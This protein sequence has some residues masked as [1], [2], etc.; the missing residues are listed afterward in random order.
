MASETARELVEEWLDED[1]YITCD[2]CPME[3]SAPSTLNLSVP[4][5]RLLLYQRCIDAGWTVAKT[6]RYLNRVL[7][8]PT[9]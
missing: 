8:L 2:D 9:R 1:A 4:D 7:P 5:A 6:A 3:Y